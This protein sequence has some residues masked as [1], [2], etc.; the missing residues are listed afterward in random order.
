MNN[1]TVQKNYRSKCDGFHCRGVRT[2][3]RRAIGKE[4]LC[5]ICSHMKRTPLAATTKTKTISSETKEM[6][7]SFGVD[8]Y[9][10]ET[11]LCTQY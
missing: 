5:V 8:F 1:I 6:T 11:D 9:P 4:E 3:A 10:L 2:A 7:F